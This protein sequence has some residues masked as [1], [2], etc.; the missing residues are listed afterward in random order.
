ML[1]LSISI[2]SVKR[3]IN[4]H[5]FAFFFASAR[6][7]SLMGLDFCHVMCVALDC[8]A[9]SSSA[10]GVS[11]VFDMVVSLLVMIKRAFQAA[12]MAGVRQPENVIGLF[13]V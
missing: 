9:W 1:I 13:A 2:A 4:N 3:V 12:F 7:R 8:T 11:G 10:N 5:R 6:S